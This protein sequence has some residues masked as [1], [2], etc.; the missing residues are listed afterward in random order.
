MP[1]GALARGVA[2]E[3]RPGLPRGEPGET[4]LERRGPGGSPRR[5]NNGPG[6]SA[7]SPAGGGVSGALSAPAGRGPRVDAPG[8]LGE[9]T[10]TLLWAGELP[11]HPARGAGLGLE[12]T[13]DGVPPS[14][15]LTDGETE[16]PRGRVLPRGRQRMS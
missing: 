4:G 6:A 9:R 15:S 13:L 2:A 16:L 11:A 5:G 10:R 1:G 7:G 12:A 14:W 8:R 3:A